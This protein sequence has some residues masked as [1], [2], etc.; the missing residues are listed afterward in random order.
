MLKNTRNR[1]YNKIRNDGFFYLLYVYTSKKDN[2][3]FSVSF[4]IMKQRK[5]VF[6]SYKTI[7][8]QNVERKGNL[9]YFTQSI[10]DFCDKSRADFHEKYSRSIR[11]VMYYGRITIPEDDKASYILVNCF[12]SVFF[13][14]RYDHG[15]WLHNPMHYKEEDDQTINNYNQFVDDL[16]AFMKESKCCLGEGAQQILQFVHNYPVV[17]NI[18]VWDIVYENLT[19]LVL[20]ANYLHPKYECKFFLDPPEATTNTRNLCQELISDL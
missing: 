5:L 7:I 18:D 17:L 1:Y 8:G 3:I 12:S 10:I 9:E 2:T 16:K 15:S 20:G 6:L 13:M 14:L 11:Y 19:P 4:T